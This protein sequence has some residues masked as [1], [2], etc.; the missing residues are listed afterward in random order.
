LNRFHR[1]FGRAV[2]IQLHGLA[3]GVIDKWAAARGFENGAGLVIGLEPQGIAIAEVGQQRDVQAVGADAEAAE[4]A[5]GHAGAHSAQQL[6]AVTG[7]GQVGGHGGSVAA[8]GGAS[9]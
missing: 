3:L 1:V 6:A 4:H 2:V 5:A 8:A 9:Q 7:K